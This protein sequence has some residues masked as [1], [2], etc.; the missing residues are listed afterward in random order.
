MVR[1]LSSYRNSTS[2]GSELLNNFDRSRSQ[3]Y[4]FI[5][6]TLFKDFVSNYQKGQTAH[7]N[8]GTH[9]VHGHLPPQEAIG[10][11]KGTCV[12]LGP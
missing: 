3:A 12:N 2:D 1:K 8:G 7:L 6:I 4:A 5:V 11:P 10:M 9:S